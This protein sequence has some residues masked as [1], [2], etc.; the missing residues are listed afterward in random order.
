[1]LSCSW[2]TPLRSMIGSSGCR[3]TPPGGTGNLQVAI[4]EEKAGWSLWPGES[5]VASWV[6]SS[7]ECAADEALGGAWYPPLLKKRTALLRKLK[8][9]FAVPI[10]ADRAGRGADEP[11]PARLGAVLCC[12]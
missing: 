3:D 12:R 6:L 7:G 4:N 11:D 10:P 2:W 8:E 1:M 5:S 9:I